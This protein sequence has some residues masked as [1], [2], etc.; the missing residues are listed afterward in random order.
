MNAEH[1]VTQL[2]DTK[3][4]LY[5][6]IVRLVGGTGYI[7][8]KMTISTNKNLVLNIQVNRLSLTYPKGEKY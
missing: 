7:V 2:R 8:E 1:K 3:I 4:S 6:G 5:R